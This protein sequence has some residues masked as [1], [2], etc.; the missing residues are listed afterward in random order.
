MFELDIGN[1]AYLR[2]F[3]Y[4]FVWFFGF[5][6]IY[7][8]A[9][10]LHPVLV[11]FVRCL[12]P[13]FF[14]YFLLFI[15]RVDFGHPQSVW[16][17]YFMLCFGLCPLL[18]FYVSFGVFGVIN[19]SIGLR[20]A[21]ESMVRCL[22]GQFSWVDTK[23]STISH[24]PNPLKIAGAKI[25]PYHQQWS[26]TS[27]PPP[28]D[29]VHTIFISGLLE[30]VKER[31]LHNLLRWFSGY[32]AWQVNFKGEHPMGFAFFSTPQLAVTVLMQ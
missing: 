18:Y 13:C 15:F 3:A 11:S 24:I 21:K 20:L 4:T 29:E 16:F 6:R 14:N 25:H 2:S 27:T 8:H 32:E 17:V 7:N 22:M 10:F 28:S 19:I 23:V 1:H 31:E 12:P 30:D 9:L 26:P 5:Y